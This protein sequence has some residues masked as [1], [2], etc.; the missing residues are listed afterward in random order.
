M[1]SKIELTP[2][3]LTDSEKDIIG[4]KIMSK[5]DSELEEVGEGEEGLLPMQI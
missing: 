1:K 2:V 3:L 5:S 4:S